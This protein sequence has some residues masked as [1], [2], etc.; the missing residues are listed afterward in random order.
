MPTL[1]ITNLLLRIPASCLRLLFPRKDIMK[2]S[3]F[4]NQGRH[5]QTFLAVL[6]RQKINGGG[7]FLVVELLAVPNTDSL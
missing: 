5:G 6:I 1:F 4:T 3:K 2:Q 7:V